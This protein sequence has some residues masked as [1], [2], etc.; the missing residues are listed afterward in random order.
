MVRS[1][2][3]H[4]Q[5]VEGRRQA[6]PLQG[7][8]GAG[9][10]CASAHDSEA[11]RRDAGCG[12][13]RAGRTPHAHW[14]PGQYLLPR[15]LDRF[16]PAVRRRKTRRNQGPEGARG[17]AAQAGRRPGGAP[18]ARTNKR[19]RSRKRCASLASPKST[20]ARSRT[21]RTR[22]TPANSAAKA[23]SARA[24]AILS[25]GCGISASCQSNV[26]SRTHRPIR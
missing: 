8:D 19:R 12:L 13:H 21:F 17:S 1:R 22:R 9:D 5:M 26:R 16:R 18:R 2:G 14:K 4:E 7:H 15:W 24:R 11:H 3:S 23:S 10:G 25:Y 20:P 6:L